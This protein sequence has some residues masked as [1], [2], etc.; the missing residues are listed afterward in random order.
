MKIIRMDS[1]MLDSFVD[2]SYRPPLPTNG[3]SINEINK[4]QLELKEEE[5]DENEYGTQ[6]AYDELYTLSLELVNKKIKRRI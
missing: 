5:N 3:D 6:Q 2:S 1:T 4:S